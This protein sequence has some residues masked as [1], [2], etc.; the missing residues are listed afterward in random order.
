MGSDIKTFATPRL[1]NR[2]AVRIEV[3]D[4]YMDSSSFDP[5]KPPVPTKMRTRRYLGAGIGLATGLVISLAT[6]RP[7]GQTILFTLV[8][9]GAGYFVGSKFLVRQTN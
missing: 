9:G 2:N 6:K 4:P 1:D 3:I 7:I 8:L 5:T